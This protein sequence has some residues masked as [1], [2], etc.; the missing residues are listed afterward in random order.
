MIDVIVSIQYHLILNL[1]YK[2]KSFS[3]DLQPN[4]KKKQ[5][6]NSIVFFQF[7]V[8]QTIRVNG[9][10]KYQYQLIPLF[11]FLRRNINKTIST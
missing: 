6:L 4:T 8:I 10:I 2:I 7:V 5:V 1:K 11:D 3:T 9:N